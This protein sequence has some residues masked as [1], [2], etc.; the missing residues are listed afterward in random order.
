MIFRARAL[1]GEV[2]GGSGHAGSEQAA[3]TQ[4][5]EGGPLAPDQVGQPIE[6]AGAARRTQFVLDAT[7][8]DEQ[9]ANGA[10]VVIAHRSLSRSEN[11]RPLV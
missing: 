1:L 7:Q 10:G 2:I 5:D 11:R 6:I 4:R 8:G 9:L 3:A